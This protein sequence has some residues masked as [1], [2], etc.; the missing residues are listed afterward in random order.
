MSNER[1]PQV[2]AA[3]FASVIG[4]YREKRGHGARHH[5]AFLAA[6]R[7][8]HAI[9]PDTP[10]TQAAHTVTQMMRDMDEFSAA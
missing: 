10:S 2:I 4:A 1:T 6:I 8:Y 7:A 3:E 9:H 5:Q